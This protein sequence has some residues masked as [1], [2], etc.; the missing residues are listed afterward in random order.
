MQLYF[1]LKRLRTGEIFLKPR[2]SRA[3]NVE[4]FDR[5]VSQSEAKF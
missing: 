5:V 2:K 4:A 3:K 1:K